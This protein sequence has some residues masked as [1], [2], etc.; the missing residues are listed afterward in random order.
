MRSL[1]KFATTSKLRLENVKN[2]NTL[3]NEA[4]TE[5]LVELGSKQLRLEAILKTTKTRINSAKHQLYWKNAKAYEAANRGALRNPTV[6][7]ASGEVVTYD[8]PSVDENGLTPEQAQAFAQ[9]QASMQQAQ[10]TSNI[11]ATTNPYTQQLGMSN[12]YGSSSIFTQ[13]PT[14]TGL[15]YQDLYQSPYQGLV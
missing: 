15:E 7:L 12:P 6:A 9:Y 8:T 1:K 13:A 4:K 14:G 5:Q 2:D 11:A 3:S 10:N